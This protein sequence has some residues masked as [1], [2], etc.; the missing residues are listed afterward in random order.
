M[1]PI[2]ESQAAVFSV[3][4]G[5]NRRSEMIFQSQK[6]AQSGHF[7][8]LGSKHLVRLQR[9]VSSKFNHTSRESG[10]KF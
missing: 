9:L 4:Y 2:T 1:V 3:S 10:N 5:E 6:S 8:A 7:K